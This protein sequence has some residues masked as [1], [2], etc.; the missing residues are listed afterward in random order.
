MRTLFQIATVMLLVM[1]PSVFAA[2]GKQSTVDIKEEFTAGRAYDA[3]FARN[4]MRDPGGVRLS[5]MQLVQDDAPGSGCSEKGPFIQYVAGDR[6]ARKDLWLDDP[7]ANGAWVVFIIKGAGG[8]PLNVTINGHK[9][10]YDP[11][12]C[13]N[14]QD[15]RWVSFDP[16]WL[17]KGMN[18]I[19]LSCPEGNEKDRWGIMFSRK[20]EFSRG[21][22]DPSQ[23]GRNSLVSAD[24]G[25]SWKRGALG[26]EGNAEGELSVRLSLDR[27]SPQ[28]ELASPVIDLWHAP[29]DGF[30]APMSRVGKVI[31][32]AAGET[33]PGA[34][35][36][37]QVRHGAG[38]DPEAG[39]WSEYRTVGEGPSASVE[40]T[41]PG[42]RFFQWKAVLST[43]DPRVTPLVKSVSVE[44]TVT[45]VDHLPDNIYV[46]DLE[47]PDILYSSVY[48]AYEPW[49]DPKLKTLREREKLDQVVGGSRTEFEIMVKL[50][51]Y[52]AKRWVWVD[53]TLQYPSWDALEILDRIDR[54]GGGGM[55]IHFAIVLIQS[56][57]SF[58]IPARLQNCLGHEVVEAWSNDYG[59][60][61]FLDP[62]QGSNVYNYSKK[63]GEPLGF[64]ELHRIY[65]DL[66]HPDHPIDWHT[67]PVV[68]HKNPPESPVGAGTLDKNWPRSSASDSL[69]CGIA[70][71]SYM[72]M[73]PRDNWLEQNDPQPLGHG[74]SEYGWADYI[75]WYDSRTPR[76]RHQ[77]NF[78]DRDADYWPTLNR[79]KMY[80]S[81]GPENDRVFLRFTSFTPNFDTYLV[82]LDDGE[83]TPSSEFFP[84]VLHSGRNALK[85]RVVNRLGSLGKPSEVVINLAD[86]PNLRERPGGNR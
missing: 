81:T 66:F 42:G 22:G 8:K 28:G 31:I 67:D 30:L 64:R 61:V 59:K 29:E 44:R 13:T 47:N 50:L 72:R 37:W 7:R 85:V 25:K 39:Y 27:H 79:V 73:M 75:N 26:S 3:G 17:K 1:A 83:W 56:L 11:S 53:P 69:F 5:D 20:D 76:Q 48:G 34:K 80:A 45:R 38:P 36:I 86:R 12:S 58:G 14:G 63:T 16:S 33:P 40:S 82:Q 52:T 10:S 2:G 6:M 4:V 71:A 49:D 18:T 41:D 65:L 15:F 43:T 23:A 54:E 21:G 77:T 62:M 24:G 70:N 19:L 78:T 57:Q 46:A 32:T 68:Y 74:L 51:D 9:T 55:C 35:I 60:W 84:W